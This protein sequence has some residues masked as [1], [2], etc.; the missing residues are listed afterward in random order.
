MGKESLPFIVTEMI[1]C[2]HRN[3]L[4]KDFQ[5]Q[6]VRWLHHKLSLASPTLNKSFKWIKINPKTSI[7]FLHYFPLSCPTDHPGCHLR[8]HL[9]TLP[10]QCFKIKLFSDLQNHQN[11]FTTLG[12]ERHVKLV[13]AKMFIVDTK[14]CFVSQL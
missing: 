13:L 8:R 4:R 3:N 10:R 9:G 7:F 2:M 14:E 12:N 6:N 1:T 11:I 5:V